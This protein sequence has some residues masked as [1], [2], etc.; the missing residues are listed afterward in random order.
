MT[1]MLTSF[2]IKCVTSIK[3]SSWLPLG[4]G[5]AWPMLCI[6]WVFPGSFIFNANLKEKKL[7]FLAILGITVVLS[8]TAFLFNPVV[9]GAWVNALHWLGYALEFHTFN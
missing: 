6:G 1:D 3:P 4:I 2:N 5:G 9:G 7:L 8:D